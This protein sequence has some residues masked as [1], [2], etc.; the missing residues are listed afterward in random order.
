VNSF[1][2][3][4][5]LGQLASPM[6]VFTAGLIVGAVLILFRLPRLGRL[7]AALAIVQLIVFSL[8]PVS[9]ALMLPLEDEARAEAAAAPACCY[10][11]IVVLGGSIGPAV[12]PLRPDPEL[13]DSSDRVWH[14]A[15]LFHRGLA[16]RIVVSGG[17]Y[18]V[19][20][21]Q[22]PQT[23][24][25]AMAMRQFLVALGVPEAAIA[26]EGKSLNTIENM[27][28]TRALVGTGK[29]A[30]V[31]SGYHM[32]RALR[33]AKRAGLNAEA[34]PTD[35]QALP[36]TSPWWESLTPSAG[37]LI[38]SGIAIREYLALAFDYRSVTVKPDP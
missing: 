5:I 10:D 30:L 35:W 17:S 14:A 8:S 34:F 15:R 18:L 37:A 6:G 24:T 26:M 16:P 25:E 9:N 36:G 20:T 19:E 28:E 13:F 32:P 12:P 22:A 11:A 29:V 21:G 38:A 33:L 1:I 4:K 23:Q 2:I 27:E 31:T 3:L 7:V